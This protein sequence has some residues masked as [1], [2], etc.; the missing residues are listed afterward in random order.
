MA[1]QRQRQADKLS[2]AWWNAPLLAISQ[3]GNGFTAVIGA[4]LERMFDGMTRRRVTWIQV[5]DEPTAMQTPKG[6]TVS[7]G[8]RR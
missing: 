1:S 4:V 6:A 3:F 5:A 7:E 2:L 8:S